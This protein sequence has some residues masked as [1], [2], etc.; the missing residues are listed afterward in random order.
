ML[1]LGGEIEVIYATFHVD[2]GET[3]FFVA[4]DYTKR[5]VC[6]GPPRAYLVRVS[7]IN[8]HSVI[9]AAKLP[10]LSKQVKFTLSTFELSYGGIN[11]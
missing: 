6:L 10:L 11:H 8:H 1:D 3:P 5:K 4:L 9:I 2:V 7:F